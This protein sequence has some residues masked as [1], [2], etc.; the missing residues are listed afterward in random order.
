MP[1]TSSPSVHCFQILAQ[2]EGTKTSAK[3]FLPNLKQKLHSG[4]LAATRGQTGVRKLTVAYHH[5]ACVLYLHDFF[6][7]KLTDFSE[8]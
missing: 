4:S 5:V 1:S 3:L 2:E 7:N 8:K 6:L